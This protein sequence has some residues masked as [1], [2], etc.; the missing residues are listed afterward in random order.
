ME[1]KIRQ[2]V[3]K[4]EPVD[5]ILR[6]HPFTKGFDQVSYCLNETE[7]KSVAQGEISDAIASRKLEDIE[8]HEGARTVYTTCF[9][10]GLLIKPKPRKII[11]SVSSKF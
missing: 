6:A 3:M 1:S 9:Y 10:I 5:S 7:V 11:L 8:G 4:L 2:L